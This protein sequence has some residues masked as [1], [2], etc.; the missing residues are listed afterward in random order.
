MVPSRALSR[1]FWRALCKSRPSLLAPER[2]ISRF[3]I[4][5]LPTAAFQDFRLGLRSVNSG[6]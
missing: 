2:L 1:R 3:V 6:L 5:D 4:S